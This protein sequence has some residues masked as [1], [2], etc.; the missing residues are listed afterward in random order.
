MG[1]D[2]AG[3]TSEDLLSRRPRRGQAA[4]PLAFSG[5]GSTGASPPLLGSTLVADPTAD[6]AVIGWVEPDRDHY[7]AARRRRLRLLRVLERSTDALIRNRR[8][9]LGVCRAFGS[10]MGFLPAA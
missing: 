6:V 3:A 2:A 7:R 5:D 9:S 10:R 8:Q 4:A 1:P